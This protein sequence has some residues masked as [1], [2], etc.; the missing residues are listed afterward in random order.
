MRS[1][2][3]LDELPSHWAKSE[4]DIGQGARWVIG[5]IVRGGDEKGWKS[6]IGKE[7]KLENRFHNLRK[8]C[9]L[10]YLFLPC[11][12]NG[13][14]V[15]ETVKPWVCHRSVEAFE[16]AKQGFSLSDYDREITR[17]LIPVATVK[18]ILFTGN[19]DWASPTNIRYI[20]EEGDRGMFF[21]L[22][23]QKTIPGV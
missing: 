14:V 4:V 20:W 5:W 2:Y 10:G 16:G 11:G 8:S 22:P 18:L 3:L 13:F 12:N 9:V 21:F 7:G 1:V 23:R 19:P 6:Q 17:N 15:D